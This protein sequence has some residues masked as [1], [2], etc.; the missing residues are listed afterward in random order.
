MTDEEA[1]NY[2]DEW[3]KMS[4]R[5]AEVKG[6]TAQIFAWHS[7]LVKFFKEIWQDGHDA[8][9]KEG[10]KEKTSMVIKKLTKEN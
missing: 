2:V 9:L 8:G 3:F 6:V 10:R 7:A 5:I 1:N 4:S